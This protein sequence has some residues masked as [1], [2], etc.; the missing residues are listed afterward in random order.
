M[1]AAAAAAAAKMGS[2]WKW[3]RVAKYS[4]HG[5]GSG[6]SRGSLKEGKLLA[7]AEAAGHAG[8]HTAAAAGAGPWTGAGRP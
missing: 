6:S 1:V 4:T 7:V 2:G 8:Q 5:G 3:L